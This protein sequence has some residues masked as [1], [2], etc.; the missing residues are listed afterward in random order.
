MDVGITAMS[1]ALGKQAAIK[2]NVA[3]IKTKRRSVRWTLCCP[4]C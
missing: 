3:I 2:L 1:L 4:F